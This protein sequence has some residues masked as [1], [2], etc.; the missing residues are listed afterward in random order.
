MK[1]Q[2]A[3][4]VTG[5]WTPFDGWGNSPSVSWIQKMNGNLLTGVEVG[6]RQ[7]KLL[8]KG[9][10]A[11]RNMNAVFQERREGQWVGGRGEKMLDVGRSQNF[12]HGLWRPEPH[13][14]RR[15]RAAGKHICIVSESWRDVARQRAWLPIRLQA[16]REA[17]PRPSGL[18]I[19]QT[20]IY[21]LNLWILNVAWIENKNVSSR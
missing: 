14:I 7:G 15:R 5:D 19:F 16:P 3:R 8:S 18:R 9:L 20:W 6:C 10:E 1:R 21:M 12:C 13:T 11:G 2:N 4:R 17:G